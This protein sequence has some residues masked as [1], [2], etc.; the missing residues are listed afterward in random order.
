[1]VGIIFDTTYTA[2]HLFYS[3]FFSV[4]NIFGLT[5]NVK[6][7]KDLDGIEMLFI[8]D[9]HFESHKKVWQQEGFIEKCNADGIKVVVF[10]NERILES[11]FPW[12]KDNLIKLKKFKNLYH[13]AIDVDDCK[14]L[15]LKL[16][17]QSLSRTFRDEISFK[18]IE[19]KN[20]VVFIGR[21][22]GKS[23]RE[24]RIIL[25]YIQKV[26]EVDIIEAKIPEWED[27]MRTIAGYRFVLSPIG[28]GN[29]FPMRFYEALAVYSIPIH[30]VRENTLDLYDIERG[31]D[32]CI[33]FSRPKD[34]KAKIQNCTLTRSHNMIWMEDNM[35]TLFNQDNLWKNKVSS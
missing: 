12:N 32:D 15:G 34:I 9:D 33:F 3:Y 28:N 5:K 21:T 29:F 8:G 10:T 6:T 25:D 16:N 1:M 19:K 31:Y 11:F 20:K 17:R 27:Y 7:L 4:S 24:R 22:N 14:K 30:Q 23:Y 13:Y 18:D 26:I 35:E 2:H